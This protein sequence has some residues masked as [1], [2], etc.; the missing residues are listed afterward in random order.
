MYGRRV[1][2]REEQLTT[3]ARAPVEQRRTDGEEHANHLVDAHGG[4][5]GEGHGVYLGVHESGAKRARDEV[6]TEAPGASSRLDQRR[7]IVTRN[8]NVMRRSGV[9]NVSVCRQTDL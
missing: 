5:H 4:L 9:D 6:V 1:E 8:N 2:R 3:S 7:S